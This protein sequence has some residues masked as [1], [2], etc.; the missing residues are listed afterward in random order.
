M[1]I[2]LDI[3][4]LRNELQVLHLIVHRNKNQHRQAKWW[5]YVSIIHRTVK[6]L[7]A[8][9]QARQQ[10]EGKPRPKKDVVR[11]GKKDRQRRRGSERRKV[12]RE[13]ETEN[14]PT[15]KAKKMV[16]RRT[17]QSKATGL[18]KL[19]MS[20]GDVE[21]I[22]FSH[23]ERAEYLVYRVIPKAFNAF[24]RLVAHGQ[25][26]TLGLV[27]LAA[28]A[29]IWHILRQDTR[30]FKPSGR[31]IPVT[32]NTTTVGETDDLGLVIKRREDEVGDMIAE[33][34]KI[35]DDDGDMIL[36]GYEDGGVDGGI[37]VYDENV[38][39]DETPMEESNISPSKTDKVERRSSE[40]M[41]DDLVSLKFFG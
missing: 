1:P 30:V 2:T 8:V 32:D 7:V 40:V 31:T 23:V 6:K 20:L 41:D 33:F 22:R 26:V 18:V 38:S 9:P 36:D 34:E 16:F 12:N 29:R 10:Q 21:P 27:L 17:E 14:A 4:A 35:R 39:E 3:P 25:Y 19:D 28:V 15:T 11:V 37:Q 5:K 13:A 24:H